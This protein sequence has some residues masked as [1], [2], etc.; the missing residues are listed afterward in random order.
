MCQCCDH[1]KVL[2]NPCDSGYYSGCRMEGRPLALSDVNGGQEIPIPNPAEVERERYFS[3]TR[4]SP[5]QLSNTSIRPLQPMEQV[6]SSA[7]PRGIWET[8]FPRG[9][10]PPPRPY[11]A[12]VELEYW[13]ENEQLTQCW[14]VR[15]RTHT[16]FFGITGFLGRLPHDRANIHRVNLSHEE[17]NAAR[18]L[19]MAR[20]VTRVIT[21][22]LQMAYNASRLPEYREWNEDYLHP[23][24][25]TGALSYHCRLCGDLCKTYP[26]HGYYLDSIEQHLGLECYYVNKECNTG[27]MAHPADLVRERVKLPQEEEERLRKAATTTSKV[28]KATLTP[29]I[30]PVIPSSEDN[31]SPDTAPPRRRRRRSSLGLR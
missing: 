29:P 12:R 15:G 14:F 24:S 21:T 1:H 25:I 18:A 31:D 8:I 19:R 20:S 11:P 26:T 2:S 9:R 10:E 6:S 23:R 16:H 28:V 3:E 30:A 17:A 27:D 5:Q 4:E 7:S 22:R 13:E